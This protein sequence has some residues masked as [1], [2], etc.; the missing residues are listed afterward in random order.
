M[1]DPGTGRA[2]SDETHAGDVPVAHDVPG[3]HDDP[4][5]ID[6]TRLLSEPAARSLADMLADRE[7]A[8]VSLSTLDG[9]VLWATT[10]GASAMYRRRLDEFAGREAESFIHPDDV[11]AYRR[12]VAAAREGETVRWRGAVST[13]D[14]HWIDISSVLW[15]IQDP[16]GRPA[17]LSI[18]FPVPD[19]T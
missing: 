2:R 14:G 12:A 16:E 17:L 15:R 5:T 3:A 7:D 10:A 13:G 1:D 8:T 19:A 4:G 6:L 9:R 11:G 18:A